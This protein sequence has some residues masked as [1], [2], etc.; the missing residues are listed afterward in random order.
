MR[1]ETSVTAISWIPSEAIRGM[2]RLPFDLSITQY[3][4]P[5]PDHLDDL[6]ALHA[7]GGFRFANQLRAWADVEDGRIVDVGQ[8]GRDL[9][10]PTLVRLGVARIAFQPTSFP[11]MRAEPD[12]GAEWATFNQTAGGRPGVPAPR[13]VK[14][15]PFVKLEG[16]N[17]WTTLRLTIRADGTTAAELTGASPFPRHWVYDDHGDLV[18]KAGMIDF[19]D[20]YARAFGEHSPWGG[21]QSAT[22]TTAAETGLERQLA[23][24]IMRGG[25]RP[26]VASLAAGDTLMK[27]GEPGTTVFLL[28]DGVLGVAVGGEQVAQLGPGAVVG[29]RALFEGGRRTAT[30]TAVTAVRVV[31][32]SEEDLEP[33]V[34]RE[35]TEGHR[36][37]ES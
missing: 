29:E 1:V 34:L 5:P 6:D 19:D 26:K 12:W 27:E 24:R 3:D 18:A 37:E 4:D 2:T 20:W 11:V 16:P 9:I 14:G 35:L 28:L 22:L 33:A 30:L 15:R 13:F 31:E 10:S 21:E 32:A 17:V 23:N 7:A 25:K 36:R 8:E